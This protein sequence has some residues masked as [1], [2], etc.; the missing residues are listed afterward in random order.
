MKPTC[1]SFTPSEVIVAMATETFSPILLTQH[2][3]ML[4][5]TDSHELIFTTCTNFGTLFH[6]LGQNVIGESGTTALADALRVNQSLTT[7]K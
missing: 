2:N 3:P 5:Q 7:L 4:S 1:V 6:S